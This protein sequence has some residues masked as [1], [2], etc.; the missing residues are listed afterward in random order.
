MSVTGDKQLFWQSGI[1]NTGLVKGKNEARGILRNL[2]KQVTGMDVFAGVGISATIA[3]AKLKGEL[4]QFSSEFEQAMKEVQ[5]ISGATQENF[6]GMSDEIIKMTTVVPEKALGMAKAFYQVASAGYDGA[7]GLGVL[8]AAAKGAVGGVTSTLIAVDGLTTV[9]NAWHLEAD[10][11]TKVSDIFFKTVQLG[12]TT[13]EE[14]ARNMATAAPIAA[15]MSVPFEQIAAAVATLTKQGAPTSI[16]ITQIRSSLLSLNDVLG[17]GWS[18]TM[19]YQE[20]LQ[21]VSDKAGGSQTKLREMM[22]RVEAMNAVLGITGENAKMAAS[23]LEAIANSAGAAEQAFRTMVSSNINQI[24]ILK[25]KVLASLKPIGDFLINFTGSI[26]GAIGDLLFEVNNEYTRAIGFSNA[27]ADSLKR[28]ETDIGRY[29]EVIERLGEK[30]E[31]TEKESVELHKAQNA[32]NILIPEMSKNWNDN[33]TAVDN[34][35]RA[36]EE[37]VKLDKDVLEQQKIALEYEIKY[38]GIQ[39]VEAEA[40][41][42]KVLKDEQA[43]QEKRVSLHKKYTSGIVE[44]IKSGSNMVAAF[45]DLEASQRTKQLEDSMALLRKQFE[46]GEISLGELGKRA[47]SVTDM[48]IGSSKKAVESEGDRIRA[49]ADSEQGVLDLMMR[50]VERKNLRGEIIAVLNGEAKARENVSKATAKAGEQAKDALPSIDDIKRRYDLYRKYSD[51]ILE[52]PK[53][54]QGT[55][56]PLNPDEAIKSLEAMRSASK[57]NAELMQEIDEMIADINLDKLKAAEDAK[58]AEKRINEERLANEKTFMM[59]IADDRGKELLRVDDYYEDLIL[60]FSSNEDRVKQLEEVW[61][62]ERQEV[63]DKYSMKDFT[64]EYQEERVKY[65]DK[66]ND[67]EMANWIKHLKALQIKYAGHADIIKLLNEDIEASEKDLA[68]TSESTWRDTMAAVVEMSGAMGVF[69][70]DI[71]DS[72]RLLADVTSIVRGIKDGTTSPIGM[73]TGS[74][75]ILAGLF[76]MFSKTTESVNQLDVV[77]ESVNRNLKRQQSLLDQ[78]HGQKEIHRLEELIRLTNLYIE[79]IKARTELGSHE[80]RVKAKDELSSLQDDLYDLMEDYKNKLTGTTRESIADAISAGFLD[81]KTEAEV[82]ADTFGSLKQTA[83]VDSFKRRIITQQLDSFYDTFE[84]YVGDNT[85]G[86]TS[87]EIGQLEEDFRGILDNSTTYWKEIQR[88]MEQAGL[89][90]GDPTSQSENSL[91]GA[92]QGMSEDTAGLLS[93]QF[94]AMRVNI[95]D[96]SDIAEKTLIETAKIA[97]NTEFNRFLESIDSR[98]REIAGSDSSRHLGV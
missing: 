74:V 78:A 80:D 89:D 76:G 63:L 13:F 3:F 97:E 56:D 60:K 62:K 66:M 73:I 44:A 32:L 10:Q 35:K 7:K 57:N 28:R 11:S 83:L 86:L 41:R 58:E 19:T 9:L 34:V 46:S 12:K 2:T 96:L 90:M 17:D 8:K 84:G 93:G 87:T 59:A 98:L 69:N 36:Q 47:G 61:L 77:L 95:I 20:A 54:V 27:Y 37:L 5:T 64:G 81:G 43:F 72:I 49:M 14:L 1:D 68:K 38:I 82:F 52:L 70:K 85:G 50:E 22:G 48:I 53:S 88:I 45:H 67:A 71:D 29:V 18:K 75:S 26:A 25:N 55:L 92:F 23:D 21:A 33:A 40:N 65:G 79:R 24:A 15:S 51:K 91:A 94:N 31:L 42:K 4:E 30:T 16:A 6:E 39:R